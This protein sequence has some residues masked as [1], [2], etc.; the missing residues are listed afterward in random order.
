MANLV[1]HM[2]SPPPDGTVVVRVFIPDI[3]SA[4]RIYCRQPEIMDLAY[5]RGTHKPIAGVCQS[6]WPARHPDDRTAAADPEHRLQA[7]R[8]F[9]HEPDR[10]DLSDLPAPLERQHVPHGFGD[11]LELRRHTARPAKRRHAESPLRQP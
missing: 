7:T 2:R 1:C 6:E 8:R 9:I 4:S 3:R 11:V 10:L 5:Q